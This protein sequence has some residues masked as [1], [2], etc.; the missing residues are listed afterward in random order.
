MIVFSLANFICASFDVNFE[1]DIK[2]EPKLKICRMSLKII[3]CLTPF[4]S[5]KN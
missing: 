1:T 3:F 5:V 2:F 4:T